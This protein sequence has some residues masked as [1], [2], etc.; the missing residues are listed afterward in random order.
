MTNL[1][2]SRLARVFRRLAPGGTCFD[3][4][5]PKRIKDFL[6][7]SSEGARIV[8][9]GS[10]TRVID[11]RIIRFDIDR[12]AGVTVIG[13]G[14]QMPFTSYSV[15]AVIL[16]G[17]LEHVLDPSTFVAETHR[18]LRSGGRV[19]VEVPFMQG[20]HPH[21]GDYQRYTKTGLQRLMRAFTEI[22]CGVCG[23]PSSALAWVASE[24]MAAHT[25]SEFGYLVAKFLGRW[26]TFW[27]K[28]LDWFSMRRPNAMVLASG[29][30]FI[31]EKR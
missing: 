8:D 17:V 23:G 3:P 10:S 13:D 30:Y 15:D 24:Y 27:I 1:R 29:F 28:Y 14:H 21:P 26:L 18:I 11:P 6:A 20:Y 12:A 9:V 2:S 22:G 16:T 31:G 4:W 5:S 25:G 7:L 19:Y